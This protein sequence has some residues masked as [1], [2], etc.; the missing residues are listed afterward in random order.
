MAPFSPIR[1]FVKSYGSGNILKST[2]SHSSSKIGHPFCSSHKFANAS[3]WDLST[4]ASNS[5]PKYAFI[6]ILSTAIQFWSNIDF[7]IYRR[8]LIFYNLNYIYICTLPSMLVISIT[9]FISSCG[10][11]RSYDD[12]M[13]QVLDTSYRVGPGFVFIESHS[14]SISAN[15]QSTNCSY[16]YYFFIIW[17]I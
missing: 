8:N 12:S 6:D 1:F 17:C 7:S 4:P 9:M 16:I 13:Q 10:I 5:K 14:E 11:T 2:K 15:I 3:S